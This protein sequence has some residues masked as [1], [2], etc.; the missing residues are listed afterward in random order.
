MSL[1]PYTSAS[2]TLS[3]PNVKIPLYYS[4]GW[5]N[6]LG[7]TSA[8]RQE[9]PYTLTITDDFL[10]QVAAIANPDYK[11][12]GPFSVISEIP[13]SIPTTDLGTVVKYSGSSITV[14]VNFSTS[15]TQYYGSAVLTNTWMP[16]ILVNSKDKP[17]TFVA[18]NRTP[19]DPDLTVWWVYL[20]SD[21]ASTNVL[22]TA[23][24][25]TVMQIS[26]EKPY[27]YVLLPAA[28][29]EIGNDLYTLNTS[30]TIVEI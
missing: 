1:N 9:M 8:I 24:F 18:T 19:T 25:S 10:V 22:K 11:Y 4:G 17:S 29:S 5:N 13:Y 26:K 14:L 28:N 6:I 23:T 27:I 20:H 2:T 21:D 15:W 3:V 7:S 12:Y 30:L 16:I